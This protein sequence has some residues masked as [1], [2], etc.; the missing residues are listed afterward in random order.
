[1]HSEPTITYHPS[2]F[3]TPSRG[4]DPGMESDQRNRFMRGI[5]KKPR[6]TLLLRALNEPPRLKK[7][8]LALKEPRVP[9]GFGQRIADIDQKIYSKGVAVESERLLYR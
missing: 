1:M 5:A 6:V 8:G 3:F 9:E 2:P 4:A 7:A